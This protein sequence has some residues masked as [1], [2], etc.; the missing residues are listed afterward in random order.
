MNLSDLLSIVDVA[1]QFVA[2]LGAIIVLVPL[3]G[4]AIV[5]LFVAALTKD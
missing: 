4:M 3:T 5:G 1:P 2:S